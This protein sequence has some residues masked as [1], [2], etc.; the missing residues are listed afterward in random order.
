MA[1]IVQKFGGTSLSNIN[2]IQRVADI[3]VGARQKGH[4]VVVV[5]SAMQGETNRLFKLAQNIVSEPNLREAD[6]LLAT[7]EQISAALLSM[8]LIEMQCPAR[9]YTG[10]QAMIYTDS[11][12]GKAQVRRIEAKVL[13]EEIAAGYVPVVAGFQGITMEGHV[14]TLGRGGSDVTAVALAAVLQAN[15]CQIYTDVEGIYTSDPRVIQEARL[16]PKVTFVEMLELAALGAEVLQQQAVEFAYRHKVP[17]R[18][19]STFEQ[20]TG[21]LVTFPDDDQV[22]PVVSGIAFDRDQARLSIVGLPN[23]SSTLRQVISVINEAGIN[24]D[25]MIPNVPTPEDCV[26]FSFTVSRKSYHKALHVTRAIAKELSA[27]EVLGESKIAKLSVV[28]LGMKSHAGAAS[29]VLQALSEEGIPIHLIT[30]SETKISA[31]V[32][33]KYLELG[34][35]TLHTAFSLDNHS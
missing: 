29:K 23:Q 14:T 7:G 28:G 10:S 16:L 19:L 5:V 32:E 35:R 31:L 11:C 13:H 21:T 2:C 8:S 24:V 22:M 18:V 17:L 34:A 6:A 20:G 27:Q 26:D 15:E 3:V 1:L 30:S 25:M 33:E 9:S 4:D 12:H